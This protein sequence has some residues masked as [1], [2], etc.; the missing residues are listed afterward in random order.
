MFICFIAICLVVPIG[1]F[2]NISIENFHYNQ[3]VRNIEKGFDV[4]AIEEGKLNTSEDDNLDALVIYQHMRDI[5]SP[6]FGMYG[7]NRSYTIIDRRTNQIYSSDSSFLTKD[8][9]TFT[10]ELFSSINFV[11]SM[12]DSEINNSDLVTINGRTFYDYAVTKDNL[13]FYFRYYKE[14]WQEMVSQFN[15][16]IIT[17]LLISLMISFIIGFLLSK[18]ITK[19]INN[20]TEKAQNIAEG[21]FGQL[22]EK[23]GN[24]EIG[25]LTSSIN[26][27]SL[28]LKNMLEEISN[29]KSKVDA[30]VNNMIDGIVA[31][32]INGNITQANP[33]SLSL[34]GRN[35][36]KENLEQI[37]HEYKINT[38]V[39]DVLN[40]TDHVNNSFLLV[41]IKD[42]ILQVG[43]A[44]LKDTNHHPEGIIMIL[45]DITKQQKLDEMR[46]EFV[47]NVS[48][49]LKT[50]L[51]SI[52][53]Y[54]ETLLSDMVDDKATQKQFLEVINSETDRMY[55]IV[56]D[57][58]QLSAM[59]LNQLYLN[60]HMHNVDEL[61]LK[62]IEKVTVEAKAKKHIL[63]TE[64]SYEDNAFFD[65]DKIQQVLINILTN[66]IKYTDEGG[67]I[68]VKT[69]RNNEFAYIS[70][71]D[72]GT[73][74]PEKDLPRIFERFYTVDK[75]RSRKLG[76]TGLGLAIAKE[77][78][79]A[80]NGNIII[81]SMK[82][83]GTTV[84][85]I[86]PINRENFNEE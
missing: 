8:E 21:E 19:P 78:M 79:L 26:E 63:C 14:D 57:L 74:I 72:N 51:T 31:F 73:G 52:K 15:N 69:I 11:S 22:L 30:I 61:V 13:V 1:L 77:I 75:A 10:T 80:H 23:A 67:S 9:K 68:T 76:G 6:S 7:N 50:P 27:M 85:M 43:F 49:E 81:E 64:L 28:S 84:T 39:S 35:D 16:S 44:I 20:I 34:L 71:I 25:Q 65:Y 12:A 40:R 54:T 42:S 70:V 38:T 48:H 86:I 4:L 18:T 45:R 2:L 17:S 66:A 36:I 82:D 58:L 47:A 3:F 5:Y 56:K 24:D 60:K 32:D 55:R 46:E 29:E 83:V 59:D 41:N 62:T 33:V 53:S 37:I